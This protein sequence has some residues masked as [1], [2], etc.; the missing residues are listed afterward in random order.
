MRSK[1]IFVIIVVSFPLYSMQLYNSEHD[2]FK[3]SPA[4]VKYIENLFKAALDWKVRSYMSVYP[5]DTFVKL[6]NRYISIATINFWKNNK[7][8]KKMP[9]QFTTKDFSSFVCQQNLVELFQAKTVYDMQ[10]CVATM[11]SVYDFFQPCNTW[12]HVLVVAQEQIKRKCGSI[13]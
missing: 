7:N 5:D 13:T 1:M 4:Q 12:E 3:P 9:T 8:R 10:I 2:S 11:G 6:L